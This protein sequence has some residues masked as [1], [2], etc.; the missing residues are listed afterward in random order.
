MYGK[1]LTHRIKI[2]SKTNVRST[3]N[4]L[5]HRMSA[6]SNVTE[7]A[8]ADASLYSTLFAQT[9]MSSYAGQ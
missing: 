1:Q 2:L 5:I 8:S 7:R 3:C 9:P 4:L 6:V